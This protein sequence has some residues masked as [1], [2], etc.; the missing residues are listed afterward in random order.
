M[1]PADRAALP[2]VREMHDLAGFVEALFGTEPGRTQVPS[3][4][5]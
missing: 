4:Q 2:E 1:K 3:D 5:D